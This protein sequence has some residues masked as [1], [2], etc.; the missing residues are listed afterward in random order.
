MQY[1]DPASTAS[2]F[3]GDLI[4]PRPLRSGLPAGLRPSRLVLACILDRSGMLKNVRVLEP[5]ASEMTAKVLAALPNWKFT[6]VLRG[7]TP[8]EVNAIL[9]FDIDTR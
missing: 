6:P 4:A 7:N 5:G 1:A 3:S 2:T 8:V 9:G